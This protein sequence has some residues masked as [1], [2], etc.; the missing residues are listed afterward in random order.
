MKAISTLTNPAGVAHSCTL[1]DADFDPAWT[2]IKIDNAVRERLIAQALLALTVR[3]RLPFEEAPMHGLILLTGEP[4]TGKTTLGRGL[5]NQ[6]ARQ[7][8]GTRTTFAEIDPHALTSSAL[9]R[10]QQAVAKLFEQTIPELAIGGV[11]IV[12]LDEVETLAASRHRLSLEANPIDVHRA[13][14]AALA[15]M[16][17]L[18][19]EH[20]NVLLIATTNFPDA[21]DEAVLSRADHIEEI[22]LP[23]A[24]A[25]RAIIADTLKSVGG[26]WKRAGSLAANADRLAQA[27]DGLDGRRIRKA[28][29]A[30]M[31]SDIDTAKDPNRLTAVQ[32][33]AAFRRALKVKKGSEK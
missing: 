3:Q 29:F 26:V 21:L 18:T 7:L 9:G 31:A 32:I 24:A 4:G 28:I 6:I 20:R 23:D 10:S 15:G 16:D 1:P 8:P 25:R 19:R 22:G 33:E 14:D 2:A 27:A 12:L 13:T 11:A 30:A 5:A 17:R